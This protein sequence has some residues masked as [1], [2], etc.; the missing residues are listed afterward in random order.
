MN[1]DKTVVARLND[2]RA[3]LKNASDPKKRAILSGYFW[4]MSSI[5]SYYF[6]N[7]EIEL[8]V[9]VWARG[10]E[11]FMHITGHGAQA[12]NFQFTSGHQMTYTDVDIMLADYAGM[13]NLV[14]GASATGPDVWNNSGQFRNLNGYYHIKIHIDKM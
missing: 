12:A 7:R 5:E 14:D 1:F 10:M 13:I 2:Q 6:G 11:M 9:D 3:A 4:M 8:D